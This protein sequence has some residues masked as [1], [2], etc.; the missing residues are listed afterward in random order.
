MSFSQKIKQLKFINKKVGIRLLFAGVML[1]R[2]FH[3]DLLV[4][5]R[6]F[7]NN[8]KKQ[9]DVSKLNSLGWKEKVNLEE[10][11][12]LVFNNFTA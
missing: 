7:A 8:P 9:L 2:Y 3:Q 4:A 12:E 6:I 1:G 11:I 5:R 10:G